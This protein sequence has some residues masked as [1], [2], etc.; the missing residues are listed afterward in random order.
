[1]ASQTLE[2]HYGF[3]SQSD[4]LLKAIHSSNPFDSGGMGG[5]KESNLVT[6]TIVPEEWHAN[7][8]D[9]TVESE[10]ITAKHYAFCVFFVPCTF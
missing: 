10:A 1:M 9:W 2:T 3:C 6:S 7:E 4:Y 5:R 8:Q